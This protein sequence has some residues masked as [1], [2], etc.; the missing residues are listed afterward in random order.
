VALITIF[1]DLFSGRSD[2][3]INISQWNVLN[4]TSMYEMFHSALA[5]NQDIG[6][7]NVSNVTNMA[8][9][10]SMLLRLIRTLVIGMYLM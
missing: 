4:A 7:W 1:V 6:N 2:F 8:Y 9:C 10:F 5:F 3:N